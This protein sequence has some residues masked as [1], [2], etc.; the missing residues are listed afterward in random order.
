MNSDI[1][2]QPQK[3]YFSI[4]Y[5]TKETADNT[6]D[7]EKLGNA[8]VNMAKV[9]KHANKTVN[10]E[11]SELQL[12]VKAQSEGS[13]VVEFVTY[14]YSSGINPL[15]ILGFMGVSG[16]AVSV[17]GALKQ[18]KSRKIK[19]V[20]P[21]EGGVSDLILDDGSVINLPSSVAEMV[22]SKS[23]RDNL[24]AIIK[25]P[26]ENATDAKFIIS[27]E[28]GVIVDAVNDGETE[29]FKSISR[30]IVEEITE[31]VDRIEIY[32]TKVNFEGTSGWQIR[33]PDD[34][35]VAVSMKDENFIAR[36]NKDT[37]KFSKASLF[38][39]QLK[40]IMTHR[41]GSSP[42]YKRELIEVVRDR[43]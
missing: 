39:V 7:A 15:S 9:L 29:D 21:K 4:S 35:L 26:L 37:Q 20:E 2:E 36:V 10:G 16:G 28:N 6:I 33:M 17:I 12:E 11:S 19:V 40:T 22:A 32:F 8:I 18:L 23:V 27:D 3:H 1:S 42:T 34:T 24:E 30:N 14:L 38:S 31:T 5:D 43:G 25:D 13:F 41:H